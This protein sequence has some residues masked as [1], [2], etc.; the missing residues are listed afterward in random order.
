MNRHQGMWLALFLCSGTVVSAESGEPARTAPPRTFCNP[1][2]LDYGPSATYRHAADPVIVLF[3]DK[4]YL[5]STL[6]RHGYHVSDDSMNWRQ[7][8][9]D[10]KAVSEAGAGK[11]AK[12]GSLAPAAAARGDYIYYFETNMGGKGHKTTPLLRTKDPLS[13]QWEKCA[14]LATDYSDPCL[15]FDDDGR[16]FVTFGM[17]GPLIAELDP[18]TFAEIKGTR[19]ELLARIPLPEPV[20]RKGLVSLIASRVIYPDGTANSFVERY[21]RDAVVKIFG[22]AKR[23][24]CAGS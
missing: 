9:W 15:F 24:A 14:D 20:A 21:P 6:N 7:I 1:L 17:G 22:R 23:R 4:Y 5:F 3:K 11:P 19:R 10:A 16:V 2:N 12:V 18:N 13:G 8:R